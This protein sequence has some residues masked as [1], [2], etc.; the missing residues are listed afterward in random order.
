MKFTEHTKIRK[1]ILVKHEKVS[2]GIQERKYAEEQIEGKQVSEQQEP[3]IGCN[4]KWKN[5]N[6]PE[7][8]R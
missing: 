8:A 2:A 4:I 7:Y 5:G 1:E 6:E 3:S